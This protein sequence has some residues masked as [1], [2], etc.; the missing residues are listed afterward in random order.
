MNHPN[1][2]LN[3]RKIN[4]DENVSQIGSIALFIQTRVKK[5][6]E[7][8]LKMFVMEFPLQTRG[9]HKA[10]HDGTVAFGYLGNPARHT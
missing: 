1:A 9:N 4:I 8:G 10:N 2:Q 7:K 3:E 6:V 5:L